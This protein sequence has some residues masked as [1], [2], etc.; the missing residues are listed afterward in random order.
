MIIVALTLALETLAPAEIQI[1]MTVATIQRLYADRL[2]K[3]HDQ[4]KWDYRLAGYRA[5]GLKSE[6]L[7]RVNVRSHKVEAVRFELNEGR[8]CER[9]EERLYAKFGDSQ[10][11][12]L[13]GRHTTA[14][15]IIA[16]GRE[17][18]EYY[19][20]WDYGS[21]WCWAERNLISQPAAHG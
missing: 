7:I 5:F 16:G 1:G 11:K 2:A 8:A 20:S 15:W 21:R 14:T 18:I 13:L 17:R 12:D 4:S 10:E 3:L 9:L 6:A 19:Y